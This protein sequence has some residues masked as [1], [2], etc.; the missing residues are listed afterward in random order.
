MNDVVEIH[1]IETK[2]FSSTQNKYGFQAEQLCPLFLLQ[3]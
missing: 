1:E 2:N 3:G